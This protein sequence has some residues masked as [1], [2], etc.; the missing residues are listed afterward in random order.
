MTQEEANYIID[1]LHAR[2]GNQYN[3]LKAAEECQ[4]LAL[5]L[6]QKVTKFNKP[7]DQE[8]IDEIGDVIIRVEILKRMYD[9][10]K[11][12]ARIDK[13]LADYKKYLDHKTY[14]QI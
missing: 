4:E 6:T 8:I 7:D 9:I 14:N 10:D 5:A 3:L 1:V 11:I 13:K 12:Q 2:N